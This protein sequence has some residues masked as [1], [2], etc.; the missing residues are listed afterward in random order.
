MGHEELSILL[1][2]I[3]GISVQV[4]AIR[5]CV[6]CGLLNQSLDSLGYSITKNRFPFL[7]RYEITRAIIM[8]INE[9]DQQHIVSFLK[10]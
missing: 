5:I 10:L 1:F 9:K 3:Y 2:L 7:S 6:S 4:S 8:C